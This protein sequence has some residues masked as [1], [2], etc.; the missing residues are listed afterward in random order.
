MIGEH[1]GLGNHGRVGLRLGAAGDVT[2]ITYHKETDGRIDLDRLVWMVFVQCNNFHNRQPVLI[3]VR[4]TDDP[5]LEV[6]IEM[7]VI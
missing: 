6:V 2:T 7:R 5:R 1:A 3:I 4:E